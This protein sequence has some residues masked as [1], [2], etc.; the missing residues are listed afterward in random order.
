MTREEGL[1]LVRRMD[2]VKPSD[3]AR[4]LKYVNM[5]EEE[6][7]RIADTFRDPRVWRI[8]RERW[9]RDEPVPPPV[10]IRGRRAGST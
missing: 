9:S 6:F 2:P 5:T 3:L 10:E 4:W 7:D 8:E 1:D